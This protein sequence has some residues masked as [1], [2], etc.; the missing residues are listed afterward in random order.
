[1][2][3]LT[4]TE[5]ATVDCLAFSP[6]GTQLAAACERANVR[7][8][9]VIAGKAPV[10]LKG[11]RS[12]QFVGFAGG[13]DRLVV[14]SSYNTPAIL[15]DLQSLAQRPLGPAPG[16]C[17]DTAL[18]PDGDRIVRA[19]RPKVFCRDVADG[20]TVWEVECRHGYDIY[21]CVGYDAAGTRVFAISDR[22]AVLD[23]ATG[24]ELSGLE[25]T[26][27]KHA[28][29]R[30]AAVSPDGR[31]VAVRG[32]DG[33]QVRD[34]SDGRLVFEEPAF[35]YGYTVAFTAD[36]SRL[37]AAPFGGAPRVEYWQT[38]SWRLLPAFDPG[39]GPIQAIA[40][41]PNGMLAAAGG[42]HGKVALWDVD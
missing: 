38:G 8:W 7:I 13:P 3:L 11:T 16:Y 29:V 37:A 42:F 2:R 36:G 40:F 21:P 4:V 25:L 26:F 19:E 1:M 20:A 23:A 31:W 15:W 27:H 5:T 18:S 6:D 24:K 17:D 33:L 35:A 10:N 12:S 34:V 14:S 30:A 39:I 9:N 32:L 41:S 28:S 22:V